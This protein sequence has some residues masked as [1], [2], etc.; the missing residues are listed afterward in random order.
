M[1]YDII[2][3]KGSMGPSYKSYL[4][5]IEVRWTPNFSIF[6]F[7]FIPHFDIFL[8][9]MQNIT[10]ACS[11]LLFNYLIPIIKAHISNEYSLSDLSKRKK[12]KYI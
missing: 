2:L 11:T 1:K 4:T 5:I 8:F 6:K 7:E 10:A 9:E 3:I 12:Y